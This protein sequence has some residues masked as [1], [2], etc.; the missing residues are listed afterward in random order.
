M[1]INEINDINRESLLTDR[2]ERLRRTK[3]SENE[4]QGGK[5]QP[6]QEMFEFSN[7]EELDDDK[8]RP[9][10]NLPLNENPPPPATPPRVL[11]KAEI[12]EVLKKKTDIA[13]GELID[14]EA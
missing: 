9:L 5:N 2:L 4:D 14:I 1:G 12:E 6:F 8:K 3:R 10:A 7:Q 11:S 13:P